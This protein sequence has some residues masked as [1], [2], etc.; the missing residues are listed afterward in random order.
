M[1]P[2]RGEYRILGGELKGMEIEPP[3]DW[4]KRRKEILARLEDE[5][6]TRLEKIEKA[7]RLTRGW[8]MTRL[9]KEI[10]KENA[11]GWEERRKE[12]E[13]EEKQKERREQ[14]DKANS[15]KKRFKEKE[16]MKARERKITEMLEKIPIVEAEKIEREIRKEEKLELAEIRKNLWKK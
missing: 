7:R 1:E 16:E 3:I 9:C 5:E 2:S 12:A 13:V 11:K 10:I 6:K 15:K 8:E 14:L 4:Q